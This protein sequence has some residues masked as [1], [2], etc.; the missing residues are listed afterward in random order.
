MASLTLEVVFLP[1]AKKEKPN[2]AGGLYEVKITIGKGV[3]GKL[4]RKSFYSSESKEDARKQAEAWK[5]EREVALRTGIGF[6]DKQKSF[7]EWADRWLETYKNP[8]VT[9]NT[10]R[11]TYELYVE[12]HL[13]PYF[14]NADLSSIRPADIQQF[15]ASKKNLSESSLHK[16]ALCLNGIFE[17]AI[18]NDLC[19]KNPARK[20]NFISTYKK[21]QKQ[22]YTEEQYH[23]VCRLCRKPVPALILSLETGLR[24]GEL[25]GLRWEDIK[26]GVLYVK[27]SIA[28]SRTELGYE[29]RPPKWDSYRAIPLSVKARNALRRLQNS[30]IYVMPAKENT[31]Y[32]PRTWAKIVQR[33]MI[34]INQENPDI[35]ILSPHELRH[36]FGTRLRRRGVDIYTI[37]KVMGHKD[38]K[39]TSETYVHSEIDV[40]K[41]AM[42]V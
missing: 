41:K 22:A 15:Y 9:E 24:P 31:P 35:P 3:N 11:G 19:Y 1:R 20:A 16:I 42:K 8:S 26:D 14:G 5:I 21:H 27:R 10:Y 37:Q 32:T 34:R 2:H 4:I 36:S 30:D 17:T 28:V 25:C 12:K 13:K 7:S 39:I 38:I 33:L 18:D 6:T 40:L 23:A 29:I